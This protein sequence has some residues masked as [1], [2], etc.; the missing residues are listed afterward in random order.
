MWCGRGSRI[1]CSGFLDV[2]SEELIDISAAQDIH[3]LYC[4]ERITA[5]QIP[6][7]SVTYTV[8][9]GDCPRRDGSIVLFDVGDDS[10]R[11]LE[12]LYSLKCAGVFDI[13]WSPAEAESCDKVSSSMCFCLD[14]NPLGMAISV[15]H[16]DST[17]S[18][19][20]S[21]SPPSKLNSNGV[22][23]SSK[24]GP[25]PS[26]CTTHTCRHN[27]FALT[28]VSKEDVRV[29]ETYEKRD[30][31][32]YGADWQREKGDVVATCSFYD[33]GGFAYGSL[34]VRRALDSFLR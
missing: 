9:G 15:G 25:L 3:V 18:V 1:R 20:S 33:W 10:I 28:D 30:S 26:I 8:C 2:I 32:T 12:T 13:K 34:R 14:W 5:T 23:T 16:S 7:N 21:Q 4:P 19:L 24:L 27:R 31:L 6:S 11:R 17:V 29:L 22:Y